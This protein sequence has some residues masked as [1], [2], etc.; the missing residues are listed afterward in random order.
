M[1]WED[2]AGSAAAAESEVCFL[3][4]YSEFTFS[5]TRN[6]TPGSNA[7]LWLASLQQT[8]RGVPLVQRQICPWVP[9]ERVAQHALETMSEEYSCWSEL[10]LLDLIYSNQKHIQPFPTI[11]CLQNLSTASPESHEPTAVHD[12]LWDSG[13]NRKLSLEQEFSFK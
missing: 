4:F 3:L 10:H 11:C 13:C 12:P 2:K 9:P 8:C 5:Y 7:C 1:Q 6:Q